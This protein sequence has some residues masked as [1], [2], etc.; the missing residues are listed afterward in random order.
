M[1]KRDYYEVLG[2]K[3]TAAAEEI[4]RAHRKLVRKYHPDVNKNDKIAEEK[5]KEVQEAYD[6]L[7]DKENGRNTTSLALP[8]RGLED[9]V[10]GR[11]EQTRLRRSVKRRGEVGA[12]VARGC[13]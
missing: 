4:R 7:S 11:V 10:V 13:A 3:K 1:A 9:S 12:G 6:V 2:I 5:F 8:G